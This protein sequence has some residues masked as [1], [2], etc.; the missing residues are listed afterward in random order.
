MSCLKCGSDTEL[1]PKEEQ[2]RKL[3]N[4]EMILEETTIRLYEKKQY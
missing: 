1:F 2:M 3:E 4:E